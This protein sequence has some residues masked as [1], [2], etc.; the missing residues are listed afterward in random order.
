MDDNG[1][2]IN[3]R[4]LP[5]PASARE[6]HTRLT[7]RM[8][9]KKVQLNVPF[10]TAATLTLLSQFDTTKPTSGDTFEQ[11]TQS[12]VPD[13]LDQQELCMITV[14]KKRLG[15]NF[16]D[17]FEEVE[18]YERP[19]GHLRILATY[20]GTVMLHDGR[21]IHFTSEWSA[22]AKE[23]CLTAILADPA[24]STIPGYARYASSLSPRRYADPS[25]SQ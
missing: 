10:R 19:P 16:A 11:A 21:D 20:V 3:L 9:V 15:D 22:L 25:L 6:I 23:V 18:G 5:L 17:H 24:I 13:D 14:L 7:A 2:E 4:N 12:F 1:I 8:Q